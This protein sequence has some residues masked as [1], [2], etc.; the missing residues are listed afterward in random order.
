[1]IKLWTD[2]RSNNRK[3][4]TILEQ[5]EKNIYFKASNG[6]ILKTELYPEIRKDIK[7]FYLQGD[8]E[9]RSH[10]MR[11]STETLKE[12]SEAIVEY[13]K[14]YK[15]G[16]RKEKQTKEFYIALTEDGDIINDK[17]FDSIDEAMKRIKEDKYLSK[18]HIYKKVAEIEATEK[19]EYKI[20]KL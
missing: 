13:N 12:I 10:K 9:T 14:I 7:T 3:Y 18:I 11:V 15:K 1:M 17:D 2:H 8:E 4:I 5:T 6:W 19:I 16:K 20:T